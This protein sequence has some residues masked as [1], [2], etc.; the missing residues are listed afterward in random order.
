MPIKNAQERT[1]LTARH[2]WGTCKLL[3]N[4]AVLDWVG[5]KWSV[6]VVVMLG[7][8]SGCYRKPRRREPYPC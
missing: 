3:D 8:R 1:S 6:L 7:R 5:D 2:S 4:T